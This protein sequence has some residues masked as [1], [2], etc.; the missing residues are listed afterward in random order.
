VAAK[1]G[2]LLELADNVYP[3]ISGGALIDENFRLLGVLVKGTP[4]GGSK[5]IAVSY[6]EIFTLRFD[7]QPIREIGA[8]I[9]PERQSKFAQLTEA[10]AKSVRRFIR[11]AL[12]IK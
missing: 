6:R 10:I 3:G 2:Q 9:S 12:R 5:N 4:G 7:F 11:W 1:Q 8:L